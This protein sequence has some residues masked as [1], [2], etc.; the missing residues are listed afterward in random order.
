[1]T[2]K[3]LPRDIA[4]RPLDNPRLIADVLDLC[5]PFPDRE[6]GAIGVLLCDGEDRLAQPMVIAEIGHPSAE[7]RLLFL[8]NIFEV[9]RQ[10]FPYGSVLLGVARED[11][12]SLTPDDELWARSAVSA[13]DGYR[14]LGVHVVTM[15]G[16]REIPRAAAAA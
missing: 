2:F 13:S 11:G 8:H 6:A 7:E 1:M 3:D 4:L 14:I 12:L 15:H 16:S 9:A 10:L 5:I